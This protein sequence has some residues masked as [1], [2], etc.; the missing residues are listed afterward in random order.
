[1]AVHGSH[2][3]EEPP[4]RCGSR[5][6]RQHGP[7][8]RRAG[9]AGGRGRARDGEPRCHGGGAAGSAERRLAALPGLRAVRPAQLDAARLRGVDARAGGGRHRG[10]HPR[11]HHAPP[12]R[13]AP[14]ERGGH[15]RRRGALRA[16]GHGQAGRASHAGRE[17]PLRR[18]ARVREAQG[19]QGP[20]PVDG[21]VR[22]LAEQRRAGSAPLQRGGGGA[23]PHAPAL[24]APGVRQ[25]LPAG[26]ADQGR[27]L[28]SAPRQAAA[29]HGQAC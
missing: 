9:A 16:G 11:A 6:P 13:L 15:Q 19:R 28:R 29:L 1:M 20:D 2:V 24:H 8:A 14:G 7:R 21:P 25:R 22:P 27:P 12:L 23:G 4:A 10:P 3:R 26:D 5:L 18:A 17:G